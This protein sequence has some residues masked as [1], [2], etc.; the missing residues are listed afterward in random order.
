M[1][2]L[3]LCLVLLDILFILMIKSGSCSIRTQ[4]DTQLTNGTTD[5]TS[6][7][8]LDLAF[9]MDCTGSMGAYIDTAR[10][11]I[12]EIVD[13]IVSS[14]NSDVRVSLVEYRDHPPQ[15]NTFVTKTYDFSDNIFMVKLWLDAARASGGGDGPE[16]VG[17]ALFKA[18]Q[19]SWRTKSTKVAVLVSDA[20]P[21]GLVPS[22]DSSFP[23]GSPTGHDPMNL[24]RVMSQMGITMYVIGC[25]PAII[26][27]R[28]FFMALDYLTG[29][30]YVPLSRPELLVDVVTGGAK[31]ELSI[32]KF[33]ELVQAAVD[34]ANATGQPI[35]KDKISQE[36]Y[37]QLVNSGTQ[38]VHLKI[39]NDTLS[40]PTD[41]A[42]LIA[43]AT[44]MAEVRL[45]FHMATLPTY[46]T[47]APGLG[48]L[49]TISHLFPY[50]TPAV[51][52]TAAPGIAY[53][54]TMTGTGTGS[55]GTGTGTGTMTGTGTGT[56]TGSLGTGDKVSVDHSE[57][58]MS[59]VDRL[60]EKVIF[61][62]R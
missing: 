11:H 29:G 24:V 56:M 7:Q 54:G 20:P 27:Y 50:F 35:D 1:Q 47:Y 9:I 22:Q 12:K 13:E 17:E 41:E 5:S 45:H 43:T 15:D 48:P 57:I 42:K 62:R 58:S 14:S 46:P 6:K 25:E 60:V 59:Q 10:R 52:F 36:V 33:Q 16:A 8:E 53:G 19:L 31:E 30:Q 49:S 34:K 38:S 32:Q 4:E 37:N 23:N 40:G 18:T 51:G 39:N 44:S 21:H 2:T 26:P 28:D 61:G 55:S 3:S